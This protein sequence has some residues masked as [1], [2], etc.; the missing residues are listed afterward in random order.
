MKLIELLLILIFLTILINLVKI[1]S[2]NKVLINLIV[3]TI[4]ILNISKSFDLFVVNA[5]TYL[6]FLYILLNIYTTRYSSIRISL[7]NSIIKKKKILSEEKLLED[8]MKRFKKTN[9]TIM[10]YN[11]FYA[12]DKIVRIFR[13]FFLR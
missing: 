1:S 7:M 5:F 2:K 10:S 12:T 8:R 6:C 4:L 3:S 13:K 9:A 11:L